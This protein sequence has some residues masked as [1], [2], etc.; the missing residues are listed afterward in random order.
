MEPLRRRSLAAVASRS[1]T[2]CAASSARIET[3]DVNA[4]PE[5]RVTRRE[6]STRRAINVPRKIPHCCV[7]VAVTLLSLPQSPD[8]IL[9]EPATMLVLLRAKFGKFQV[10]ALPS[11]PVTASAETKAPGAALQG[12]I[13]FAGVKTAATAG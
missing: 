3:C 7:P 1:K 9:P 5:I 8:A 12:S 10:T 13:G 4:N 6:S 11:P 2:A